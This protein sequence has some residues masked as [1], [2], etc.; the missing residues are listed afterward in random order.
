MEIELSRNRKYVQKTETPDEKMH[1][2]WKRLLS[3]VR[4]SGARAEGNT[5]KGAKPPSLASIVN[6]ISD[7]DWTEKFINVYI[8]AD[9]LTAG[10]HT[11]LLNRKGHFLFVS[12]LWRH[13]YF[14]KEGV[15]PLQLLQDAV[16]YPVKSKMMN[17][18]PALTVSGGHGL[19]S[20]DVFLIPL[21][22]PSP[23]SAVHVDSAER[24]SP[25]VY[26]RKQQVSQPHRRSRR[27]VDA[28]HQR[29]ARRHALEGTALHWPLG[30][31]KAWVG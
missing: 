15:V 3:G 13:Y 27:A 4:D 20:C 24:S 1:L 29:A 14:R 21:D 23:I 10:R 30:E 8:P 17:V 31:E 19:W 18:H 28:V 9:D 26:Y 2:A 7:K 25:A 16:G 12:D 5:G 6:A 11:F 22:D